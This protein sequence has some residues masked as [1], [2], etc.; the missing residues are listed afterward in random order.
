MSNLL[1]HKSLVVRYQGIAPPP[2]APDMWIGPLYILILSNDGM[3]DINAWWKHTEAP[4][5]RFLNSSIDSRSPVSCSKR[6]YAELMIST[7][8]QTLSRARR[9]SLRQCFSDPKLLLK[10]NK[11][12][13]QLVLMRLIPL[14]LS[15]QEDQ[16]SHP[17]TGGITS[18]LKATA[19]TLL[20]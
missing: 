20:K 4:Y 17:H 10:E 18:Y 16:V 9:N 14:D 6:R 11:G 12:R 5:W 8:S 3:I 2:S 19:K 13:F 1:C 15:P 7:S